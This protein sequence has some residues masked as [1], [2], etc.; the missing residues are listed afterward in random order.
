METPLGAQ[1][2]RIGFRLY[3]NGSLESFEPAKPVTIKPVIGDIVAFDQNAVGMDADFNSVRFNE[4][5]ELQGLCT[6]SDIVINNKTTGERKIIY[7]QMRFEMTSDKMVKVP[8]KI[9]FQDNTVTIDNGVE[10]LSCSTE[11]SKFLFLH[12]GYYMDKKCSPGSDCSGCG[13]ECI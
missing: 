6:N 7:Q 5:G 12:D 10:N 11:E 1:N 9:L 3:E 13:S 2:V 8:V 4:K